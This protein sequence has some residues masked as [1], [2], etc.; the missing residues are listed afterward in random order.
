MP[1]RRRVARRKPARKNPKARRGRKGGKKSGLSPTRQYAT[2]V[3]TL[4]T[5]DVFS[6]V[7][8][9]AAFTLSSF[10]RATTIAKNFKFYRAK[11]VKWEY[12]PAYN[13]FQEGNSTGTVSKPQMYL[14]MNRDQDTKFANLPAADALFSIQSQGAD[15]SP[16][17]KNKE[18]IYRPNWCSPG[19]TAVGVT[20]EIGSKDVVNAVYSLGMK[21]QYGWLPTPN[22]DAWQNPAVSNIP[23]N[24]LVGVIANSEMSPLLN[25]GVVYNGHCFYIAQENEPNTAVGKCVVTVEWEFKGGKQLYAESAPGV[26]AEKPATTVV[27]PA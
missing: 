3:E 6:D 19:L 27:L 12:M 10:F 17:V 2:I 26:T 8:Y 21:T 15:P 13:T 18:I 4:A 20:K 23:Q 5:N 9:Q 22:V 11:K 14:M 1:A 7:P 25:G 16:F 24:P